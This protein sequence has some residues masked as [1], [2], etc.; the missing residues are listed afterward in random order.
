MRVLGFVK[1]SSDL[2]RKE[3][4]ATLVIHHISNS[5]SWSQKAV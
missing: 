4:L 2:P 1:R 3:R 5:S